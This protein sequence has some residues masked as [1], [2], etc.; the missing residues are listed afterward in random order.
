MISDER[1]QNNCALKHPFQRDDKRGKK[2]KRN[3]TISAM[4]DREEEEVAEAE[5]EVLKAEEKTTVMG[6][7]KKI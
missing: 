3:R 5:A 6:C 7:I 4:S 1:S 2:K